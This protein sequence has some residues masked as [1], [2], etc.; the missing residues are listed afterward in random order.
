MEILLCVFTVNLRRRDLRSRSR[1]SMRE[2]E[3]MRDRVRGCEIEIEGWKCV[4]GLG[5]PLRQYTD[6]QAN[7]RLSFS[8]CPSNSEKTSCS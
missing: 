4:C 3:E 8:S 6:V 7:E 1:L 5:E 2:L